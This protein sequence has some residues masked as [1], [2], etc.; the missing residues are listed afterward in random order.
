M[1]LLRR[2]LRYTFNTA[3]RVSWLHT[4]RQDFLRDSQQMWFMESSARGRMLVALPWKMCWP[5]ARLRMSAHIEDE[6][7]HFHRTESSIRCL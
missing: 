7:D 1:A 2:R 4:V 6:S 5:T 3:W